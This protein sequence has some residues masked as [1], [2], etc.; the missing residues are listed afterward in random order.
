MSYNY[1][2][3]V[4]SVPEECFQVV[5]NIWFKRERIDG[6][7][8]I[9]KILVLK[10]KLSRTLYIPLWIMQYLSETIFIAKFPLRGWLWIEFWKFPLFF[11]LCHQV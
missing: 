10:R 11:E 7:F 2:L 5:E 9:F 3:N 1:V 8:K 4:F 6:S